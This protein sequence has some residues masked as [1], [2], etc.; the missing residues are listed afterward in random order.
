[1]NVGSCLGIGLLL[2]FSRFASQHGTDKLGRLITAAPKP[3]QNHH[4]FQINFNKCP[5]GLHPGQEIGHWQAQLTEWQPGLSV[6]ARSCE[7]A[8]CPAQDARM[9]VAPCP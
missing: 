4:V 7:W 5:C 9:L 3:S 1:M 2:L 8:L 6:G